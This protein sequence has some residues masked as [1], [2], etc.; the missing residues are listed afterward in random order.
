MGGYVGWNAGDKDDGSDSKAYQVAPVS[1]WP[2]MRALILV[3]S[4]AKKDVSST[5]GM[6]ATVATSTLFQSRARDAVPKRMG[7]MT[8]AIQEKDFERFAKVTMMDSNSFHACCADTYPPIFYMNDVSRAVV[9][10][11][12]VLNEKAGRTVCAYTYDAGPNAVIYYEEA[13]ADLM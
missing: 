7:E 3:A 1:H 12:E 8:K 11:V 9:R 5:A 6:Q 4:A 10:F 2:E 13:N